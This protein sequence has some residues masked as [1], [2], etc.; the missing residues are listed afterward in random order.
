M[1]DDSAPVEVQASVDREATPKEFSTTGLVAR[2]YLLGW[3]QP[4]KIAVL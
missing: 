4:P 3:S 1:Q 2:Q